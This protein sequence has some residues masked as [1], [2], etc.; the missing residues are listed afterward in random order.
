MPIRRYKFVRKDLLIAKR[1]LKYHYGIP[2]YFTYNFSRLFNIWEDFAHCTVINTQSVVLRTD[3]RLSDKMSGTLADLGRGTVGV[4]LSSL[5]CTQQ[6]KQHRV[7]ETDANT[8]S[9]GLHA[10]A[11]VGC[12]PKKHVFG[13]ASWQA[14]IR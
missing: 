14:N 10:W 11:L 2:L 1:C 3:I 8:I 5:Q 7:N 4:I 9:E 13:C 12:P 6:K